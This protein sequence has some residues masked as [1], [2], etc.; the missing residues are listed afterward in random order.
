MRKVCY[1][2]IIGGGMEVKQL[3]KKITMKMRKIL[4][5]GEKGE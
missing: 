2:N 3:I 5:M 4:Q 1:K